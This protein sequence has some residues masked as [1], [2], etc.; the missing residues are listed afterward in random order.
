MATTLWILGDQL[1]PVHPALAGSECGEDLQVLMIESADRIQRLPFHAKKL[2][3]LI[4]AMRHQAE[5]LRET[6]YTVDYQQAQDMLSA[7]K[8]HCDEFQPDR[9][10]VMRASSFRGRAFQQGAVRQIGNHS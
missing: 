7:I 5:T 3:L 1:S 2:I 4:S 10:V 9:L 6:G 8:A